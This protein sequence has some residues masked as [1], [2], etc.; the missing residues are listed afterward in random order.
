MPSILISYLR[1][2]LLPF[3][4][5][6]TALTPR[7]LFHS[8]V[9]V[10]YGVQAETCRCPDNT[11]LSVISPIA[12]RVQHHIHPYTTRQ[13]LFILEIFIQALVPF[14]FRLLDISTVF[15]SGMR[16]TTIPFID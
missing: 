7:V 5:L 8:V 13:R 4:S 11:T 16:S 14:G 10:V 15:H 2:V 3:I 6:L 9:R 12:Y 1:I